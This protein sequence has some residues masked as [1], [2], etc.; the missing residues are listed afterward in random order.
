MTPK[1]IVIGF[2]VVVL[3]R[4]RAG[5]GHRAA[6][7]SRGRGGATS[8]SPGGAASTSDEVHTLTGSPWCGQPIT[9]RPAANGRLATA[10]GP[11]QLTARS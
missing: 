1:A 5:A 8:P 10:A 2:S 3:A 7:R 4:R 9:G 6:A 11:G